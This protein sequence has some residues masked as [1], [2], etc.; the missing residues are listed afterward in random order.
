MCVNDL[1]ESQTL[2]SISGMQGKGKSIP[3]LANTPNV[4]IVG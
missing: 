1:E 3:K 4:V 2:G